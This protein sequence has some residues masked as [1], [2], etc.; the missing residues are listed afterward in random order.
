MKSENYT[1]EDLRDKKYGELLKIGKTEK[2]IEALLKYQKD[3]V[4]TEDIEDTISEDAEAVIAALEDAASS[5]VLENTD[6]TNPQEVESTLEFLSDIQFPDSFFAEED[7]PPQVEAAPAERGHYRKSNENAVRNA[8]HVTKRRRTATFDIG[9][10][11]ENST[12][13]EVVSAPKRRRTSTFKVLTETDKNSPA[14]DVSP[15]VSNQQTEENNEQLNQ[16]V[17]KISNKRQTRKSVVA[18]VATPAVLS[19]DHHRPTTRKRTVSATSKPEAKSPLETATEEK[20][21]TSNVQ[22]MSR[23]K[24]LVKTATPSSTRRSQ[25]GMKCP[26]TTHS[27]TKAKQGAKIV[28]PIFTVG[29]ADPPNAKKEGSKHDGSNIPRF[30]SYARKLKVPNFAKIH[31]RAFSRMEALDDYIDKKR[32]RTDTTG[33]STKKPPVAQEKVFQP[34]VTSVKNLNFNF[35]STRSPAFSKLKSIQKPE[36]PTHKSLASPPKSSKGSPKGVQVFGKTI[37]EAPKSINKPSKSSRT[38]KKSVTL[39]STKTENE[40]NTQQTPRV[41]LRN[42]AGERKSSTKLGSETASKVTSVRRFTSS[43]HCGAL[44][45]LKENVKPANQSLITPA[46]V[47]LLASQKSSPGAAQKR[48]DYDPKATINKPLGYVPYKGAMKP[49]PDRATLKNMALR[50][51]NIKSSQQIREGQ[52]KILKGVRFNKRFELQMANRG[53]NL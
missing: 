40:S 52:K 47:K 34:T 49:L 41:S 22:S 48:T 18:A 9:K 27:N 29:R 53:I 16:L 11:T 23:Q 15:A 6:S 10:K 30:L 1:H 17:H 13:E 46:P 35:V 24:S 43:V 44:P 12:E 42:T 37:K 51:P 25:I 26:V 39:R 28:K 38:A 3:N 32:K 8:Q 19:E 5:D 36:M 45:Q 50:N 20:H 7:D 2:L 21:Q 14:T 31:E 4:K 33:S